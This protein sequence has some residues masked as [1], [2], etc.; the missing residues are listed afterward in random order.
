MQFNRQF[1]WR[2]KNVNFSAYNNNNVSFYEGLADAYFFV[3][4]K[5]PE[6]YGKKLLSFALFRSEFGRL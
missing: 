4:I 5:T 6:A 2:N 1:L 3:I